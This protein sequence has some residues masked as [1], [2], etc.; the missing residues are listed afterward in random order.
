[1]LTEL[2]MT[3]SDQNREIKSL[4]THEK[5]IG[6]INR[7]L[8]ETKIYF[9]TFVKISFGNLLTIIFKPASFDDNKMIKI[10]YIFTFMVK[11]LLKL[12]L[13]VYY[14]YV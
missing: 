6:C 14:I 7:K 4:V 8:E 11:I 3:L 9:L 2:N 10:Y 13:V 5:R 12:W 1:M